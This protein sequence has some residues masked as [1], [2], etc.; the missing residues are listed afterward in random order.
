MGYRRKESG[1]KSTMA[2][3]R[4]NMT[5]AGN[6]CSLRLGNQI[7]PSGSRFPPRR[8]AVRLL[9]DEGTNSRQF[10]AEDTVIFPSDFG[11][12]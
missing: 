5:L 12:G 3:A 7:A 4:V 1:E 8:A 6:F 2:K 11:G 9:P 10:L